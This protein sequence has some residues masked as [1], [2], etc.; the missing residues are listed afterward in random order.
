VAGSKKKSTLEKRTL[1]LWALLA[2]ENA[3]AFQNELKPEPE[4]ADR[5][6]LSAEG[7][8]K[9]EKRGQRIW[10][11][12][13]DKGWAWAGNNLG[14]ALPKNSSAA[15][16]ILQACLARLKAFMDARGMVLADILGPQD[17]AQAG[18]ADKGATGS[19]KF[20]TLDYQALR[21]RI[22][23]AYLDVTGGRLNTRA[24]LSDLRGK[25]HEIERGTLDD[26][27]KKMQ[28]DQEAS[29][30]QLDNRSEITDADRTAAIYFGNEPR[31]IL[32]I[33][34]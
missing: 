8:I 23:Q 9:W 31:H 26:A 6:A 3:A 33:E 30:Y 5:D 34:R 29:L 12:V 17:S 15:G 2:G 14:A 10:I 20:A 27:L 32:W 19:L 7:L 28:R 24:L 22:R 25:L 21:D 18:A 1:I 4:K 16:L 11:E 13:T